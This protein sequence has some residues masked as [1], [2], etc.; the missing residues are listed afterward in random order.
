MQ[1]KAE[2][3]LANK[4]SWTESVIRAVADPMFTVDQEKTVTFVERDRG[5]ARRLLPRGDRRAQVPRDLPGRGLPRG[6]PLRARAAQRDLPRGRA[7]GGQPAAGEPRRAG[8]RRRAA[9][10]GEGQRRLPRDPARR[11]GGEEEPDEPRR[12][13]QA[14]PGRLDPDPQ[15]RRR[16]PLE[17]RGAE[18]EHLRAVLLGQGGR[19]DDRGARHHLAADRGEGRAGRALGAEVGRG[20]QGGAGRG[21]RGDGDDAADP[22]ARRGR[23]PSRSSGSRSRRSRSAR[24]SPR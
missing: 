3:K 18:E 8:Q 16:D 4:T 23:S 1:R 13:H 7:R 6:L 21:A 22:R 24:S 19:D 20:L 2:R 12:G 9:L 11:H 14:R 10:R 15:H 5:G 17:H